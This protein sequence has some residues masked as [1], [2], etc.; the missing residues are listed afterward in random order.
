MIGPEI[1]SENPEGVSIILC[2]F[3]GKSRLEPTLDAFRKQKETGTIP[4]EIVLVDNASTDGTADFAKAFMAGS[5]V[6]FR[7]VYE[8]QPGLSF[9][10]KKGI[11]E[12]RYEYLCKVD[13]DNWVEELYISKI[14]KAIS[15]RKD[16]GIVGCYGTG[17]FEVE[18]GDFVHKFQNALALG[19]Q[20]SKS[21]Y[22]D[23][24]QGYIYGACSAFRKS[25]WNYLF[26][27]GF[28]MF[29]SG[30]KGKN[31]S[32]GDDS[33][34]S[35][36]M[37]IL[38]Y[39]LWYDPDIK[40]KHYMPKGRLQWSYFKKLFKAFGRADI[41]ICQY[42]SMI[43]QLAPK[44]KLICRNYLITLF[45][46]S[47]HLIQE[48]L[49]YLSMLVTRKDYHRRVLFLHRQFANFSALLKSRKLFCEVRKNLDNA[50]WAAQAR[51]STA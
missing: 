20:G 31:L 26:A 16:V 27:H 44:K 10:M 21:G 19:P 14:F 29:S 33:E 4:W 38:G 1:R 24:E 3:N 23:Q 2:T 32:S 41:V 46:S 6:D 25:V 48:T 43:P 42:K 51:K 7:V 12:A 18:P 11:G 37:M 30:R 17:A 8:S 39:R 15:G 13:D 40:F 45:Y 5:E 47:Y 36:A 22:I 35:L 34:L 9:A 49:R 28:V 50:E